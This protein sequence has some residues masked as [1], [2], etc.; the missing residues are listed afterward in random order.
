MARPA[1]PNTETCLTTLRQLRVP[2]GGATGWQINQFLYLLQR[3]ASQ[4]KIEDP[5]AKE[6]IIF[7]KEVAYRNAAHRD[8]VMSQAE[9]ALD[10]NS[11]EEVNAK[12]NRKEGWR[13][14]L[15]VWGTCAEAV[16]DCKASAVNLFLVASA[17]SLAWEKSQEYR[18]SDEGDDVAAARQR[19]YRRQADWH[20]YAIKIESRKVWIY[21]GS[22]NPP[23]SRQDSQRRRIGQ[24]SWMNRA[25]DLINA[26]RNERYLTI[27]EIHYGGGGNNSD[28]CQDMACEWLRGEVMR[29]MGHAGGVIPVH[30]WERLS[31]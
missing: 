14:E 4:Y 10:D 15:A 22:Y 2:D 25:R 5:S 16:R 29:Y 3:G 21:D 31:L 18:L 17:P 6:V 13:K 11:E 24:I 26:Y 30:N 8:T 9:N 1:T 23:P 7:Q 20:A 19:H 28:R 27:C 12:E